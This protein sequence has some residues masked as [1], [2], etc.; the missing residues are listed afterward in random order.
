VKKLCFPAM[1]AVFLLFYTNELQAQTT[2]PKLNQSEL[3]KQFIGSWKCDMAKDTTKLWE[4]KS[5]GTGLEGNFKYVTKDKI[6]LEGKELWGYDRKIDKFILTSMI[7]GMDIEIYAVW[8]TSKNKYV[9]IPFSDISNPERASFT[10]EGYI[11]SPDK[12][13]ETTIVNNKTVKIDNW[14]RIKE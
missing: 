13:T 5:Y 12:F 7:K 11:K 10:V 2:Q 6:V 1:I 14:T 8:F 3:M 9:V 4:S